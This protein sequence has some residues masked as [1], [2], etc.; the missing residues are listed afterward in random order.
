MKGISQNSALA[1]GGA[2]GHGT[3]IHGF[4]LKSGDIHPSVEGRVGR[5]KNMKSSIEGVAV[6]VKRF[7]SAAE[8]IGGFE[9][10]HLVSVLFASKRNSKASQASSNDGD[11]HDLASQC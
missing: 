1:C 5:V 7:H 8:F 9:Q 11:V 10:G 4:A 2:N 3:G 6:H